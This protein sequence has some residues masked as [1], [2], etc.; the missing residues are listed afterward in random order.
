[1]VVLSGSADKPGFLLGMLGKRDSADLISLG[2]IEIYG[3]DEEYNRGAG[4]K[5]LRMKGR[6]RRAKMPGDS[7]LVPLID[8]VFITYS[9]VAG[10]SWKNT[11]AKKPTKS[12]S[13]NCAEKAW[14]IRY[15]IDSLLL[16]FCKL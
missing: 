5:M 4:K 10:N 3:K 1:M 15:R 11:G 9:V 7:K 12:R 8:S 14:L 2:D 16:F 13:R 6:R